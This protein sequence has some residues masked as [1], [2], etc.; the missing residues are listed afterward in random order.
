MS[1]QSPAPAPAGLPLT[2][3]TPWRVVGI[4]RMSWHRLLS[5]GAAPL[6][7]D[8]GLARGVYLVAHLVA[9]LES[10]PLAQR[11]TRKGGNATTPA[12]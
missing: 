11:R 1:P 12:A 4:S 8:V 5:A 3:R 6:P 7:I 9:W 2:T 10:R